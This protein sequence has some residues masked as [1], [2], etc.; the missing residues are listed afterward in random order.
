MRNRDSPAYRIQ[1]AR[2]AALVSVRLGWREIVD[3]RAVNLVL[4]QVIGVSLFAFYAVYGLRA[5][6]A[7][8]YA[9]ALQRF[10]IVQQSD[11]IGEFYGSR[12]SPQV[13]DQLLALGAAEIIPEIH[14]T[15]GTSM[16]D[17]AL[18]RGVSPEHVTRVEQFDLISGRALQPG[19]APR[20][21]MIGQ[22]L[23]SARQVGVGERISLRGRDFTVIGVFRVGTYVDNE[24][25]ISLSDAQALLG[26]EEDLSVYVIPDDGVLQEGDTLGETVSVVRKGEVANGIA[27]QASPLLEMLAAVATALGLVAA[28]TLTNVLGRLAKLRQRE[29]A[30]L[31]AVGFGKVTLVGYLL[32]QALV[33]VLPGWLL[34]LTGAALL[35]SVADISY[36][37]LSVPLVIDGR[38][39]LASLALAA[40]I[41]VG[42][43][44]IPVL[45]LNRL[46]VAHLLR[47]E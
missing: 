31:R 1:L 25:W 26:W 30:I 46:D 9:G 3:N 21:A 10:L 40:L 34:G 33:V 37:G 13:G 6:M 16:R 2:S 19:D 20:L 17:A 32:V 39:L 4:A 43:V 23:A 35:A 14:T 28:I 44:F 18:V 7:A 38:L 24:A 11:S 12:L 36:L 22:R 47:S 15:T 41:T 29:L 5:G 45:W 27:R 42:G 8:E